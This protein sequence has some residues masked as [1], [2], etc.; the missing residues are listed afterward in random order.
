MNQSAPA[1]PRPPVGAVGY[2]FVSSRPLDLQP[3]TAASELTVSPSIALAAAA[4]GWGLLAGAVTGGVVGAV[5]GALTGRPVILL[6]ATVYGTALGMVVAVVPAALGAAGVADLA[7][8]QPSPLSPEG[9]A[10]DLGRLFAQLVGL[11]LAIVGIVA[12]FAAVNAGELWSVAVGLG[13][14]A[15]PAA[16][17]AAVLRRANRALTRRL[18]IAHG[19]T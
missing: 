17:T 14:L 8:R 12:V 18:A 10:A 1:R 7:R 2:W 9:L 19:W 13:L 11:L 5:V 16:I 15:L 3:P 4:F 6:V